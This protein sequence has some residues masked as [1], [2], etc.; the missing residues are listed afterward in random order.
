VKNAENLCFNVSGKT[1]S[2]SSSLF[3]FNKSS[4]GLSGYDCD[5]ECTFITV[6]ILLSAIYLF[7]LFAANNVLHCHKYSTMLHA[8]VAGG[9]V[10]C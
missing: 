2:S 4:S 10:Q 8:S 1:S 7:Q 5:Y 9:S 3:A 6:P